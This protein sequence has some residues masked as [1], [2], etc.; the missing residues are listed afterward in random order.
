MK[1]MIIS[2]ISNGKE[3]ETMHTTANGE[4]AEQVTSFL[5]LGHKITEDGR[6]ETNLKKENRNGE[7]YI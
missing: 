5:Y 3:R 6:S 1:P 7:K 4:I 2:K